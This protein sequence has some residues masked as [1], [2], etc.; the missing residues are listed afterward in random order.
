MKHFNIIRAKGTFYA[1]RMLPIGSIMGNIITHYTFYDK[2]KKKR[3]NAKRNVIY[4]CTDFKPVRRHAL[5][6]DKDCIL[7]E[8]VYRLQLLDQETGKWY[9]TN[10]DCAS[11]RELG[12]YLQEKITKFQLENTEVEYYDTN[13]QICSVTPKE[14]KLP[15]TYDKIR[16]RINTNQITDF[17]AIPNWEDG[18]MRKQYNHY[19]SGITQGFHKH[20]K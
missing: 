1:G 2:S 11:L 18:N 20:K 14:R 13:R 8:N 10:T 16:C 3:V 7:Y 4:V 5:T 12:N 17:S 9:N 15:S 19:S 6:P